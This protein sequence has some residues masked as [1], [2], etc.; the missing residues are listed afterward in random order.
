MLIDI[1]IPAYNEAASLSELVERIIASIKDVGLETCEHQQDPLIS[2][3]IYIADNCSQ[4]NTL[5]VVRDLQIAHPGKIVYIRNKRNY[6]YELSVWNLMR[7]SK[8]DAAVHILSDLED[9]P[10]LVGH[11]ISLWFTS[12]GS[13]DA[14]LAAK[15]PDHNESTFYRYG[16]RFYYILSNIFLRT[17]LPIGYHGVGIYSAH[18]IQDAVWLFGRSS[19]NMR[20]C[21]VNCIDS[22]EVIPYTKQKR[23]HGRSSLNLRGN[24]SFAIAS[25][26]RQQQVYHLFIRLI[27]ICSAIFFVICLLFALLNQ[28][29]NGAYPSGILTLAAINAAVG[30][31]TTLSIYLLSSQISAV[32]KSRHGLR[33]RYDRYE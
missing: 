13:I 7:L 20:S 19:L 32:P 11:L 33:V 6:G 27:F 14:Y 8:G 28:L 31:L 23:K 18:A 17:D 12:N 30:I 15:Q 10:E 22:Y 4:D 5:D 9:P 25:I 29:L 16:R 21:I 24:A 1:L 2:Y 3:R 26:F